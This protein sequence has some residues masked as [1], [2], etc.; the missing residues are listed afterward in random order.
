MLRWRM[1]A[2]VLL[3]AVLP[4]VAARAELPLE[5]AYPAVALAGPLGAKGAVLWNHGI[6]FLYGSEASAAPVPILM[7]V[8]RDAGW[9]VFRLPR[10]RMSEEPRSSAAEVAAAAHRLKRRGYARIVLAGQSGGAWL[11]LMAAGRSDDI[12]A[13]IANSPA[14]YGTD[15]A[16]FG[17]NGFVLLGYL[18][19]IRRAR[20]MIN[21]FAD[22]P[23]DPGGRGA[24]SDAIL[25]R[26][27]VPHLIIDQPQGLFGHNAGDSALFM[28]RFGACMLAVAG[29]GPMP[30]RE[31]CDS[32]WGR[33]PSAAI[34]LPPDLAIAVADGG[35]ADP[36]LGRW[37]GW[38]PN[39][40]EVMLVIEHAD[41]T[42]VAAVYAVGDGPD[43]AWKAGTRRRKG[44]I[45]DGKLVFAEEGSSTLRY[46]LG[47]DGSLAAQWIAADGA[48]S[49]EA[50]LRR[51]P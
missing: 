38:Y 45:V 15:R 19:E 33:A 47:H 24:R 22:D 32:G 2:L 26:H 39:G 14:Y 37:Y 29:E 40:R 42:E 21:Y 7:T 30:T 8:F 43:P 20:I 10:P 35:P 11:S 34:M 44:H 49:L 17:K 31:S 41:G 4:S 50:T 23:Y 36:F 27:N 6:N 18:A 51:V 12:D 25:A 5:P 28:R 13:V 48:S 3:A 16:V 46:E 9:D 1:V